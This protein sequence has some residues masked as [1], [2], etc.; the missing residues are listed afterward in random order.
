M[1]FGLCNAPA[2][3]QRCMT[4]IFDELV[5]DI[6]EVLGAVLGQRRDKH[7]Q[8]IY[9]ASKTLTA[10]QENYTTTEKE[11]LVVVFAFDK[12]RSY[13]ILSKV[14]V[15]ID[16]SSLHYLLNKTDTKPRLIRWI[17]L[18]QEFNLEIQDKK[19]AK[20]LEADHLS[21]LEKSNTRELDD[22][23]INDSFP[24]E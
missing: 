1:S 3:F 4:A 15:Y 22:I 6:M 20:N 2:T 19:G 16:H 18:L 13:L 11:L 8:P 17:L 5:E 7:F 23:E 24:E 9:Y 14:V 10:A 21:R 12:F